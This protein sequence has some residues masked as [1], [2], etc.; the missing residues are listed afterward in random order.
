MSREKQQVPQPGDEAQHGPRPEQCSSPAVQGLGVIGA[1]R[2]S[3]EGHAKTEEGQETVQPPSHE[4]DDSKWIHN[5]SP[6]G[7]RT[8]VD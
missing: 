4:E 8:D 3:R 2:Q 6:G 7:W 5:I 1:A